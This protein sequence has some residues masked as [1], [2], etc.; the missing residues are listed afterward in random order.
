MREDPIVVHAVGTEV[1]YGPEFGLT[2]EVN[3]VCIGR[4]G[5]IEYEVVYW[6]KGELK[7][8]WLHKDQVDAT[9]NSKYRAVGFHATNA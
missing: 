5:R 6:D 2:A 8:L 7:T 3:K 9:T 1:C 4:D